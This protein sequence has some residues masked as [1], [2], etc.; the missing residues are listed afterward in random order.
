MILVV[1]ALGSNF[2]V[3]LPV[4]ASERLGAS[5]EG[6]GLIFSVFGIGALVGSLAQASVAATLGRMVTACAGFSAAYL[7]LVPVHALA[8][9]AVLVLVA[10]ACFTIWTASN[11]AMLQLTAPDHLRGRVISLYLF[12]FAGIAPLGSLL[13]GWLA[14]LHGVGLALAVA[15]TSGLVAS[16]VTLALLRRE[17]GPTAVAA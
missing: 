5:P 4:L 17:P 11:Q 15:G 7:L 9:A 2:H 3:L 16:A 6:F 14:D 1:G 12:A 13:S 8:A 10:G